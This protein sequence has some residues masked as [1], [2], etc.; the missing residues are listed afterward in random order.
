MVEALLTPEI[1]KSLTHYLDENPKCDL[2]DAYL[3]VLE[4]RHKLKP[5]LFPAGKKIYESADSAVKHLEKENKLCHEA[6]VQ[7]SF[8]KETV[9]EKTKKI[10]ICPFDGKVYGDNTS[11]NPQDSIYEHVAKC[12]S[13][14]ERSGGLPVRRFFVSED[15]EMIAKYRTERKAPVKRKVY[16]SVITGRL[17]S[18]PTAV[19]RDFRENHVKPVTIAEALGQNRFELEENFLNFLQKQLEEENVAAFVEEM[20]EIDEFAPHVSRWIEA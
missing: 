12:P 20:A 13:N 14:T 3:L 6:E 4:K 9:N 2:V 17:F 1:K 10:Y 15:P 18:S 19:M 11:A 7:I 8:S 16:S 5:V